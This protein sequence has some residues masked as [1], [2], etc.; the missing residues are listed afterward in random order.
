MPLIV[1]ERL[2]LGYKFQDQNAPIEL[3]KLI[4]VQTVEDYTFVP[5]TEDALRVLNNLGASTIGFEP[6]RTRYAWPKI[7]GKYAPMHHQVVTSAFATM[8]PFSF[9][10]ND[11]R[12][13]KTASVI[14]ASDYLKQRNKIKGVLVLCTMTCME[15][16]WKPE[17]FGVV[18]SASIAVLHGTK[19]KRQRLLAEEYDYYVINHDGIKVVANE[20]KAAIESGRINAIIMDEGSEF[21]HHD[22]DRWRSLQGITK[23]P[24][25][26]YLWWMSATP[27]PSG[28]EDAWA[29]V[30]L[31][32]PQNIT[33]FITHWRD[34]T[35]RQISPYK[36]IAR[37]GWQEQ[38]H[39]VMQPAV[40]FA[41]K[42]VLDL[43]PLIY[44]D[45]K[46]SL[47]PAQV[48]ALEQVKKEGAIMSSSGSITAVN[49]AIL[50]GKMMQ[51]AAGAVRAD[52]G[53]VVQYDSAPRMKAL[54]DAIA[55]G[56]AKT[57][58]F[59][60]NHATLDM[61][62]ASLKKDGLRVAQVDGRVTGGERTRR[63]QGFQ[64]GDLYDF[65]VLHPKPAGH[66]LELSA[67]DQIVWFT[68]PFS[69]DLY[70]QASN[71]IQSG[72]Q[73]RD[74]SIVHIYCTAFEKAIYA[75]RKANVEDMAVVLEL[76]KA[77]Q[78]EKF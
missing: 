29:Q 32:A 52:N 26:H 61:I 34:A 36:W 73:T 59:A 72:K 17:I 39:T 31:V 14:W 69:T 12:T 16:V 3:A 11:M 2:A 54:K 24:G 38:V 22:T 71:R 53:Q 9:I 62:A 50:L 66:G 13:G 77:A 4:P 65:L 6:I 15:S 23:L 48:K 27:V 42:D 57:L 8:N 1:P 41:K 46:A 44:V 33:K 75:A 40:R 67:A 76:Y 10:L 63:I 60:N 28:P 68:P 35:M 19:D 37:P 51:I 20:I 56:K 45:R 21:R 5:H 47:T 43:P 49:A 25:V 30:R 78:Q 58:I 7:N 64:T 55:E 70:H 18:P 74:M